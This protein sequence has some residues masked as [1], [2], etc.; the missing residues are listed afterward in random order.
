MNKRLLYFLLSILCLVIGVV[1]YYFFKKDVLVYE[2]F[3]GIQKMNAEGYSFADWLP[4]LCWE[5]SF[6]FMLSSI[7][8]NWRLVPLSIKI[9]TLSVIVGTELVQMRGWLPGTGDVKDILVYFIGF[10]IFTLLFL[11][12]RTKKNL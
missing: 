6:L 5:I 3:I 12:K 9:A 7:W 10:S 1:V 2:A 4:E 11:I 8:G